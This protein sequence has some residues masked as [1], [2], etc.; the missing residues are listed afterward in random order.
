VADGVRS[1][2]TFAASAS[3]IEAWTVE[4]G[5]VTGSPRAR[6]LAI[7]SSVVIPSWWAIS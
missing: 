4:L 2:R 5:L 7:T 1:A 3:A 6:S